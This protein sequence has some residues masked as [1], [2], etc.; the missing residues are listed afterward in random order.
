MA[1]EKFKK[2]AVKR[3]KLASF[4]YIL[5]VMGL[6]F[7]LGNLQ[8]LH[9]EKYTDK[10]ILQQQKNEII[11]PKRGTITDRNGKVLAV[12]IRT[13]D[14]WVEKLYV[15]SEENAK[16]NAEILNKALGIDTEVF[17]KEFNSDKKRFNIAKNVP[18]EKVDEMK[19]MKIGEKGLK[20]VYFESNS[21]R[22][23]PYGQFASHIIGHVSK[24]N[25]G[26]SGIE[27][28]LDK[29]LR[30][31][32][33]RRIIVRDGA[34]RAVPDSE[35]R[36]N[37]PIDGYEVTLTI[38]E[39]IQ[40][41][42][43]K[44]TNQALVDNNAV[45]VTSIVMNPKTGEILAMASKPDFNPN[46]PQKILFD[47]L[48][49]QYNNAKTQEE[50][51]AVISNMWRNPS[52]NNV[53]EP[54]STF[55]VITAATALEKNLVRS[56]EAFYDSGSVVVHD[57]TIKN[58]TSVPY[59]RV[60]FRKATVESINTVFVEVGKRIGGPEFLKY[61][62]AF[63]F[64]EK[65]GIEIPGEATGII[66]SEKN[67][68]PVELAN[69]SFGQGIAVTPIQMV[70]AAS[71]IANDG[72]LIRPT[73][74]KEIRTTDGD[75]VKRNEIEVVKNPI[76]ADTANKVMDI[77]ES[78]GQAAVR[79][80]IDGYRVAGKSG[81]AQKP[82]N[83]KYGGAYI[84]SFV[85]IVPVEDPQLVVM[86]IVDQPRTGTIYGGAIA[87]PVVKNIMEYSLRYLGINPDGVEEEYEKQKITI[88]EIRNLS[89]KEA[90]K[91]L[92]SKNLK[93]RSAT[94]AVPVEDNQ[95]VLDCFPKP[96]EK[97]AQGS[98]IILYLRNNNEEITMPD[99]KG[100][101]LDEASLILEA[102]GLKPS[103][104]GVGIVK[105]QS[106][107]AG[108]KAKVGSIISLDLAE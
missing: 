25:H 40:R 58:W 14:V 20:G 36:F 66:Y 52:V 17:M 103:F 29:E 73:L 94:T 82:I 43:E 47:E 59:G 63:G 70:T 78:V 55:K 30:G 35:I 81:T 96:G 93:Y 13:H 32:Y 50:R 4:I 42:V 62:H 7:Q 72:K 1:G 91:L 49:K 2:L 34:N 11:M 83:G 79:A 46:E 71:V 3:I 67:L 88:P 5:L 8:I 19:D 53:Y 84:G 23:Y 33:G 41:Y 106:P 65:T 22:D 80:Q 85:G 68:R 64:G 37:E 10:A 16:V 57:R 54:G 75:I 105:E 31:V 21:H 74:I 44:A 87:A 98:E 95:I 92:D 56:D 76:S 102:L 97:I 61:I 9:P 51:S 108:Q 99:L 15:E 107:K 86:T 18:Q 27:S 69:V 45:S 101:T 100:K 28:Y 89:V 48:Q 38:D 24:D 77:M 90:S 12:S 6:I 60:D 26:L 39:V 104:N